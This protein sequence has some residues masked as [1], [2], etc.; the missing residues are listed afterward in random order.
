VKKQQQ[1]MEGPQVSISQ[2]DYLLLQQAKLTAS[3]NQGGFSQPEANGR[4]HSAHASPL[5]PLGERD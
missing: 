5:R 2:E 4:M 3:R 1:R